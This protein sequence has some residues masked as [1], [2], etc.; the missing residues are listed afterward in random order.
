MF[1]SLQI[2]NNLDPVW[3]VAVLGYVKGGNKVECPEKERIQLVLNLVNGDETA[4]S[5]IEKACTSAFEYV[6]AVYT[7]EMTLKTQRFRLE[8]EGL[9]QLTES[10][11]VTRRRKH[12][13]LIDDIRIANRYLFKNYGQDI[14]EGGIY[15]GDPWHLSEDNL[16]RIAVGDWAGRLVYAFFEERKR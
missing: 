15:S 11:D 12:D 8:G 14:P 7:M 3:V 2:L 4:C 5:L 10:L 16:N 9:R 1:K 13:L 6:A